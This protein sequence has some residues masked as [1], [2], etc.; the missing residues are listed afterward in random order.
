[1]TLDLELR[2]AGPRPR[3]VG[4]PSTSAGVVDVTAGVRSLLV[5]VDGR[6]ARPST[7]P[8]ALLREAE[9]RARRRRATS[10]SPSRIVH[11]PLSW[12]DPATR[13]AIERYMHGV[14]A[15]APWCPW[16]IEFIRRIN[17]LD[18]RRRRAPHR[19]RRVA[20]SCSASATCTSA[21][22][23]PRRSTPATGW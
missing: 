3:P 5:Q 19:V 9:R 22:R 15:D 1:M 21:R 20:T 12:D 11:L 4:A 2:A 16:N 8:H 10:R 7:A 14:R 6:R 13:E 18:T 23:W 17:G